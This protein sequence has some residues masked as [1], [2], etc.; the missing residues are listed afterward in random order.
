MEFDTGKRSAIVI[1]VDINEKASKLCSRE[2]KFRGAFKVVE[3]Y[4]GAKPSS[5]YLNCTGMSHDCLGE[6]KNQLIQCVICAGIHKVPD[7]RCRVTG[8]TVKIDKI[9]THVIPKCVNCG[10]KY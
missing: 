9:C 10:V 4:W 6:Y 1:I 3:K 7:H 2:L 5:V 8:C